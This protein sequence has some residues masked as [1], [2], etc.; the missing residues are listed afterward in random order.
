MPGIESMSKNLK[1]SRSRV[2]PSRHLVVLSVWGLMEVNGRLMLQK[3]ELGFC[4]SDVN[5]LISLASF[6]PVQ[7]LHSVQSL[8]GTIARPRIKALV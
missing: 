4:V 3:Y 7:V 5:L 2:A 6:L 8:S 1:K